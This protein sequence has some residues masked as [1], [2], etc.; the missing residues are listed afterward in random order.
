MSLRIVG[1]PL[2]ILPEYDSIS[3]AFEVASQLRVEW[4]NGGLNGI[5][6]WPEPVPAPYVKDYDQTEGEGPENWQKMWDLSNWGIFSA[7]DEGRRVGAAAVAWRTPGVHML[8]GRDDLAALW[9]IRVQPNRR[10]RGAGT[11]L[12]Q[13]VVSWARERRCRQI[14]IETQNSNVPACR[15]YAKQGCRLGGVR[16]GVYLDFPNE[17]QLL[18]YLDL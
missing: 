1:E 13:R 6:L 18:W 5:R 15:F 7:L 14:K 9:D 8:E 17:I 16:P 10:G 11:A 2:S 3:A 4:V 12:F